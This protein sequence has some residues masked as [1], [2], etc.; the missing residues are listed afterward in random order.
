MARTH[1]ATYA[2]LGA[3]TGKRVGCAYIYDHSEVRE[4]MRRPYFRWRNTAC[5]R[6]RMKRA[7]PKA[8]P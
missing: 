3:M 5:E 7:Y 8:K 4:A 1:I 6:A 2:L